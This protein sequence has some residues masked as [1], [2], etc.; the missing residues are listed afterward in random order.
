MTD[1]TIQEFDLKA[2]QAE[3]DSGSIFYQ[4]Q[5]KALVFEIKVCLCGGSWF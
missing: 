4:I 2:L 3:R 5:I 1:T